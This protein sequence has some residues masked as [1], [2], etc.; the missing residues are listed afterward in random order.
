MKIINQLLLLCLLALGVPS[1]MGQVEIHEWTNKGGRTIRA[2]FVSGDAE[3][4]TIFTKGSN[5]T[6]K[7]ADLGPES[8]ALARKLTVPPS[9]NAN[10]PK[11]SAAPRSSVTKKGPLPTIRVAES[12]WGGASLRDIGKILN[13]SA[14][15]LWPHASQ[16]RLDTIIVDRSTSGPIVLFRRGNEKQYLV[17]LNTHK[18]FWSQ[19]AFQFAH[20]FGHIMF[21][22]KAG[23]QTNQW[24]EESLCEAAS[25]FALRRMSDAWKTAPPYPNWKSYGPSFRK[26]AQDRIDEHPWPKPKSIAAWYRE[27]AK[28]LAENATDR[29]KN[30][31]V[32][33]QLLPLFEKNP[34]RWAATA[35][36]NIRKTN[37]T[38]DF[39]TYLTDWR[40]A[41]PAKDKP[42]AIKIAGLF[43]MKLPAE[44]R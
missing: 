5:F 42:F 41:C 21:G 24:F 4:V 11:P 15:Q 8:Q 3:T 10:S 20:E 22:Y 32:A 23:D 1:A 27:N 17:R 6:I 43:G 12:D 19:Y 30:T 44:R 34:K 7:L 38:R 14:E 26:Y 25:L 13:S 28:A 2:K 29:K 40:N 35:Y 31:T 36:L 18:T 37:K 39:T 33:T 16:D 9:T